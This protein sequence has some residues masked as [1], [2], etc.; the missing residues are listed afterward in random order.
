MVGNLI[1]FVLSTVHLEI[2]GLESD[3]RIL[4]TFSTLGMWAFMPQ[5][6]HLYTINCLSEYLY[7]T[8]Y[9]MIKIGNLTPSPL[10]ECEI[11]WDNVFKIQRIVPDIEY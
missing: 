7:N 6:P 1:P 11:K 9:Y 5:S 4:K 3:S 2:M 8:Y 10:L